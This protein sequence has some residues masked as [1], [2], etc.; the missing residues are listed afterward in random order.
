[1]DLISFIGKQLF[2]CMLG[3]EAILL[4]V[5][6]MSFGRTVLP[7]A[8]GK[9]VYQSLGLEIASAIRDSISFKGKQLFVLAYA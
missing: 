7:S 2:L 9:S 3:E 4:F 6:V 5:D 8:R 1:M